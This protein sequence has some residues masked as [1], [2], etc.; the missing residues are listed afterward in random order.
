MQIVEE[1]HL[2][3]QAS[4]VSAPGGIRVQS[5]AE[6]VVDARLIQAR[7]TAQGNE[8][9]DMN[10]TEEHDTKIGCESG[11]GGCRLACGGATRP[12]G[13][14]VDRCA[15]AEISGSEGSSSAVGGGSR[16]SLGQRVSVGGSADVGK[17]I[18]GATV[19]RLI[20]EIRVAAEYF[21]KDSASPWQCSLRRLAGERVETLTPLVGRSN[22]TNKDEDSIRR[23][24]TFL[25]A[26]REASMD[27]R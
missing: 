3:P 20:N 7:V 4:D 1:T 14:I 2:S 15:D 5:G 27:T 6:A 19:Q 16:A 18:T 25:L 10:G 22:F 21:K 9:A 26:L 23:G 24:Q 8:A 11:A 13:G 12:S 17:V